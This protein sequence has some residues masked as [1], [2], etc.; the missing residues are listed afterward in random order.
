MLQVLLGLLLRQRGESALEGDTLLELPVFGC[1]Q[2]FVQLGLAGNYD[3]N[4]LFFLGF[5]VL[6]QTQALDCSGGEVLRLVQHDDH[7]AARRH[8]ADG[9]VVQPANEIDLGEFFAGF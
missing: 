9:E 3:L 1:R 4:Q 6:Y 5:E 8:L 2:L 7:V